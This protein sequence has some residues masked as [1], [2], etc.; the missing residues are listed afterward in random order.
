M[1]SEAAAKSDC[2]SDF[3]GSLTRRD[4]LAQ[5]ITVGVTGVEDALNVVKSEQIGGIFIG[6]WTDHGLLAKQQIDRVKAAANVP[7][8]VTIDEEGG[9]VSRVADLIG[10]VPSA[11]VI[12]RTVPENAA[13]QQALQRG[14]DLAALGITVNF[15]PVV[16][17]SGQSDGEVIGDRSYSSDPRIVTDYA[18]AFARGMQD[19]GVRP[20]IKHFPGHGRG[21]GDSHQSGVVTPPLAELQ[22]SDLAPFRDLVSDEVGVM[23]GHLTV[24]GLTT[25]GVPAS[26]SP[27]AMKLLRKGTG[28]SAKPFD[29]VIFT[30]DLQGMEAIRG[31]MDLP[32]AVIAALVAGADVALWISTDEVPAVLDRLEAEVTADRLSEDRVDESV[33]RV[34]HFKGALDC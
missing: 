23:V 20:V 26:V 34:A 14:K 9:R 30:D 18:D 22:K 7:L 6:G 25:D 32:S 21:A 1:R 10:P 19:A 27:E 28:Y 11:R 12:A 3:L 16:D 24:P 17:V 31:Q 8:M 4:K 33:I 15:A 13:Y 5:L 29:G 2:E